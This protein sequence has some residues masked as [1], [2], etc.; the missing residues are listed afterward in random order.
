MGRVGTNL[1][2]TE[3]RDDL[4]SGVH[5]LNFVHENHV[6]SALVVGVPVVDE[7][8]DDQEHDDGEGHEDAGVD[9]PAE[10][11][12]AEEEAP[13]APP[14]LVG[15]GVL[16][17]RRG[18]EPELVVGRGVESV[19]VR[20]ELLRGGHGLAVELEGLVADLAGQAP[21]LEDPVAEAALVNLADRAPAL[22]RRDER[23]L[24]R[25]DL[26]AEPALLLLGRSGPLPLPLARG[27]ALAQLAEGVRH[28]LDQFDLL[29][30]P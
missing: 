13:E 19:A 23:V 15:G 18:F 8:D 10:A 29:D 1:C 12:V 2:P 26:E 17:P 21:L 22:A 9:P 6:F 16:V 20:E 3:A 7:E 25:A 28:R 14:P 30:P 4:E 5:G 24:R 27:L 11:L